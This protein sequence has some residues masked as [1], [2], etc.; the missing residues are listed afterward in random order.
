LVI[1]CFIAAFNLPY[2][3]LN[4]TYFAG[5][6]GFVVLGYYLAN[7]R[8]KILDNMW[9]WIFVFIIA[10][11]IRIIITYHLSLEQSAYFAYNG[12]HL[13]TAL[14]ASS[15]FLAV[16]NFNIHKSIKKCS[17][18]FKKG[19]LGNMTYSISLYSYGI[20]LMHYLLFP[21]FNLFSLNFVDRNALKWIP[22]LTIVVLIISWV[23]LAIMYRIPLIKKGSG[24]H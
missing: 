1:T 16:K 17:N 5:P 15:I 14:Q 21:I 3:S 11:I 7:K 19:L 8:N 10:T 4:L 9:L 6:I 20:Y 23:I 24:V 18:F 2:F 12:Y 22:F 13:L